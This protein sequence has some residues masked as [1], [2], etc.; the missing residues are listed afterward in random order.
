MR[1]TSARKNCSNIGLDASIRSSSPPPA[2]A[3]TKRFVKRLA[4]AFGEC[5][6]ESAAYGACLKNR[7]EAVEK[8]ACEKEFRALEKCF[9]A[10]LKKH[11]S[12][13]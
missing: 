3:D 13:F 10:G 4:A 5:T 9:K 12:K 7:Y 1:I 6:T 2:P 8:S 11:K